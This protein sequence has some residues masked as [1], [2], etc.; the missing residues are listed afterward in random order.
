MQ[1][2]LV[3]LSKQWP[4]NREIGKP[5]KDCIDSLFLV[6][7]FYKEPKC[8]HNAALNRQCKEGCHDHCSNILV[9][10]QWAQANKG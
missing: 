8:C 6:C 2:I 7:M 9:L 3:L 10:M 5:S 4:V 1:N